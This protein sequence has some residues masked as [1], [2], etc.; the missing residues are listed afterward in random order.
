MKEERKDQVQEQFGRQAYYYSFS[1]THTQKDS[2]ELVVQLCQPAPDLQVLDVATGTGHTALAL[3]P[4]VRQVIGL[5]LTYQMIAQGKKLALSRQ[6][7]N[8]EWCVADVEA[9]PFADNF[10]HRVTCRIAPHHFAHIQESLAEMARVLQP[11]GIMVIMDNMS[12]EEEEL[13]HFLNQ[14]EW[15]RD[16]SHVRHYTESEWRTMLEQAG[17]QITSCIITD[18]FHEYADWTLR[19]GTTGAAEAQ[20][21][22]LLLQANKACRIY[23]QIE[24]RGEEVIR[25]KADRITLQAMKPVKR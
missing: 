11:G 3:A 2:L 12:P 4:H 23:F 19:S 13:N 20:V 22:A 18:F 8:V 5:D 1:R 10:F 25:F 14:I 7:K 15:L 9:I 17:L 16:P 21:R 6:T 24:T